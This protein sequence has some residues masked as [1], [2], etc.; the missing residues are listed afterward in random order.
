MLMDAGRDLRLTLCEID[1]L[2]KLETLIL[3][4]PSAMM[5]TAL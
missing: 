1:W 5:A 3:L 2:E 4:Y